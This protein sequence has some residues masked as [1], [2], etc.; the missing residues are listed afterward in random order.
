MGTY[1][2]FKIGDVSVLE[3]KNSVDLTTLTFFVESE[4]RARIG[5]LVVAEPELVEKIDGEE[6]P[7]A[8]FGYETTVEV[9]RDRLDVMGYTAAHVREAFR[10]ELAGWLQANEEMS[11]DSL[12]ADDFALIQSMTFEDW[13]ATAYE[14]LTTHRYEDCH[15]R[16]SGKPHE[17][18]CVVRGDLSVSE[19]WLLGFPADD[20]RLAI[21]ALLTKF[22]DDTRVAY[23]LT[24]MFL[25]E[26]DLIKQPLTVEARI[27]LAADYPLSQKTIVLTEGSSD[28]WIIAGAL[29]LL[30]P[31]LT[32]YFGFLDFEATRAPGSAATLVQTIKAFAAAGIANRVV[33]VFDNDTAAAE[34]LLALNGVRLPSNIRVVR[35]PDIELARAYPTLGPAGLQ[36]LEVNGLAGGIE[37]YLGRDVLLDES[38]QLAPV[39]WRGFNDRLKKYQGE[40]VGKER[41]HQRFREKLSRNEGKQIPR[42]AEA[43]REMRCLLERVLMA[44]G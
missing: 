13:L 17:V 19:D 24:A 15:E 31:H 29:R 40:V 12:F 28:A 35:A 6:V 38:G 25:E 9:V 43:W 37:L 22:S 18:A 39:Q 23:D 16:H 34:A 32:D 3:V 10:T 14:G 8:F 20:C 41:L 11:E 1:S 44:F 4:R 21:R 5:Q 42:D 7:D 2:E 36:L 30:Y 27:D 33:A 26:W